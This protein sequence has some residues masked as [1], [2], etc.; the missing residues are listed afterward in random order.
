MVRKLVAADLSSAEARIFAHYSG[1]ERL[2]AVYAKGEDL[3]S[4][5]AIDVF[6]RSDLSA[7]PEAPN[8][9]KKIEPDLRS[10]VKVFC[11]TD[12]TMVEVKGRGL[13]SIRDVEL[14]DYVNTVQGYR[15]VTNLFKRNARIKR[16]VTNRSMF[17]ATSDHPFWSKDRNSWVDVKDLKV[18][19]ELQFSQ[20][21]IPDNSTEIRLPVKSYQAFRDKNLPESNLLTLDITEN[22]AWAIGAFLGDGLGSY[23]TKKNFHKSKGTESTTISSYIG[24]CGLSEDRVMERWDLFM[25]SLGYTPKKKLLKKGNGKRNVDTSLVHSNELIR[26]FED[27]LNL[28]VDKKEEVG[29]RTGRKNLRL[30]PWVFNSPYKIRLAMLAGI[31]DTDGYLKS[32]SKKPLSDVYLCSKSFDFIS[33]VSN[34]LNSMGIGHSTFTSWNRTYEKNYYMI[35]IHQV[36]V[37]KLAQLNL[38]RHL[39]VPRKIKALKD[40]LK[41]APIDRYAGSKCLVKEVEDLDE[42]ETVYDITVEGIHEFIANGTRVHN[43]LAVPYGASGFQIAAAMNYLDSN[44]K[45]DSARGQALIDKYLSTYPNLRKYMIKQELMFKKHGYVRNLFGRIRR[46]EAAHALYKRYGDQLLDLRWAKKNGLQNERKTVKKAL[47][48]AKNFPIQSSCASLVNRAMI[49]VGIWIKESGIDCRVLLQVH[50]ELCYD[51]DA[52]VTDIVSER[53]KYYM[54]NNKYT[55]R[56]NV[57]LTAEPVVADNLGEAK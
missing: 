36:G 21:L 27:T 47:N 9:V 41:K 35:R 17:K 5:V 20:T 26:I 19:E 28:I 7:D 42:T 12:S 45:P 48:A 1:D 56:L 25:N 31:L 43:C 33:D 57:S 15:R 30:P 39:T 6:G 22:W 49:E 8:F 37:Y 32:H 51:C 13:V 34:L 16:V 54:E 23:T 14:N 38:Q 40:R 53:L 18:N 11:F 50:D 3:Y 55:K 29:N 46:F 52:S 4:R 2:Q 10:T 44:G 24:M